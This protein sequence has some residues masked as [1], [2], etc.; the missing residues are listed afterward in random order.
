[1]NKDRLTKMIKRHEGFRSYIYLDSVGV[2]TVGYGRAIGRI[3]IS[4]DE[5]LY[6]LKNDIDRAITGLQEFPWFKDLDSVRQEALIDMA[7]NLGIEGFKKFKR[8]ISALENKSYA[9]AAI[10]SQ[11]SKWA[12]Q[13]GPR[14]KEIGYL[15]TYG[16]YP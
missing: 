3:G 15:I 7:F 13:V 10:E 9:Q 14:A 5:A 6:L 11:D 12:E 2:Q 8:M 1:M 16:K 4:E